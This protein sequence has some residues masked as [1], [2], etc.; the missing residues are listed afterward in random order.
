MKNRWLISEQ[1][2]FL[3]RIGE[4]L[5]R[6]YSL[7][8]SIESISYQMKENK[9]A[10]VYY[11][12]TLLKEGFPFY[13]VLQ[14]IGFHPTL[15][16]YVY[17]AEQHGG[18]AHSFI[19]AS[20]YMLNRQK[21]K[22]ELIKLLTYPII[23]TVITLILFL[24]VDRFL[25]PQ[26]TSLFRS[27]GLESNLFTKI[28]LVFGSFL[29]ILG[30]LLLFLFFV[31]LL[32]YLLVF[33]KYPAMK[34]KNT[35]ISIPL[36]GSFYQLLLTHYF[37]VQLSYLLAGGLS[38]FEAVSLFENN[39][40][41]QFDQ[42]IG[43]FLKEQLLRGSS[44]EELIETQMLFSADLAFIIRHGQR[45]GRLDQELYFF[46]KYCM[47]TFQDRLN[48]LLK[49]IQPTVYCLVGL[50]IISMYLSILLPMFHLMDGI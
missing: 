15:I 8:E 29:P 39:E 27:M 46:S 26:F 11:C 10:Q 18:L 4:L 9:K 12:V 13:R 24:F 28:I 2:L 48:R 41:N 21:D 23:L 34:Q 43:C 20:K 44:L 49:Y 19:E 42:E 16:G 35:L 50:L 14:E 25:L 3:K 33:R 30:Y 31:L 1:A 17:F 38:I 40:K 6:G 7:A 36:F 22:Q 37:S 32:Y 5:E 47:N 45:N